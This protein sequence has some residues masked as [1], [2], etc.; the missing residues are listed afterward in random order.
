[1]FEL[2]ET[3]EHGNGKLYKFVKNVTIA[4]SLT[5]RLRSIAN[6]YDLCDFCLPK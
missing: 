6:H 3:T 1:M 4:G 5:D 2:Y